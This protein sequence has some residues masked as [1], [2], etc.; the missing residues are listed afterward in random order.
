MSDFLYE[1]TPPTLINGRLISYTIPIK[2]EIF[3]LALVKSNGKNRMI[4]W[5]DSQH[6]LAIGAVVTLRAWGAERFDKIRQQ[7]TQLFE[8]AVIDT[9][10]EKI[11]PRLFGGFAFRDDFIPDNTWVDFAAAEFILPHYQ[12]T[13]LSSGCFLTINAQVQDGESIE[14]IQT[15]LQEALQAMITDTIKSEPIAMRPAMFQSITYPMN[16][17]AWQDMIV[18][19]TKRINAGEL[20]KVVLSRMA[21]AQYEEPIDLLGVLTNLI[22]NPKTYRFIFEPR[23]HVAFFG[24]TPEILVEVKD[25][26]LKTMAL[27]GTIK[28]GKDPEETHAFAQT[29]LNDLKERHEHQ[30]VIDRIAERL[31]RFSTQVDIGETGVLEL[32]TIQHL[33]TPISANLQPNTNIFTLLEHLHP[34]PA[35]GGEPREI[36]LQLI[37][38]LEPMPRGWFGA[39]IGWVDAQMNGKFAV[40]IRSAI[41]QH[42]R[43]WL[44]SGAG[45]VGESQPQREWD[46]TALKFKSMLTALAIKD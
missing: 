46:E 23:Q 6:V 2:E 10:N 25:N 40:A 19:A 7:V 45:I 14:E 34:T 42:N 5:E 33:Y 24:A 8:G 11:Q 36:A 22:T 12:F 9:P 21:E 26:T 18:N 39:P 20:K 35:L 4:W 1:T 31:A 37:S 28:R 3:G 32:K 30:L 43:V 16:Y 38:E 17:D 13:R 41:A 27:A 15:A 29:L 44:Y